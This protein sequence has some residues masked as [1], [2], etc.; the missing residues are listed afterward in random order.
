MRVT[1]YNFQKI[2]HATNEGYDE[3]APP[4]SNDPES[5]I[6]S[7]W[8]SNLTSSL[9][10]EIVDK[11]PV[12]AFYS[13]SPL[14]KVYLYTKFGDSWTV[15][16]MYYLS[17]V[18]K[19]KSCSVVLIRINNP[20][21]QICSRVNSNLTYSLTLKIGDK[22]SVSAFYSNPQVNYKMFLKIRFGD[23]PHTKLLGKM[24]C[25]LS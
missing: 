12:S 24:V 10:L 21:S 6:C 25:I 23:F 16:S 15:T 18:F 19:P 9:V 4:R 13:N 20:E 11:I 2:A 3:P 22:I 1:G 5:Q 14:K 8:N 7:K 17:T